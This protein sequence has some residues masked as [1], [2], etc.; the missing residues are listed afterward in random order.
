MRRWRNVGTHDPRKER[1]RRRPC[2][3]V[4]LAENWP[5]A[6]SNIPEEPTSV[7][8][9]AGEVLV[10]GSEELV[11]VGWAELSVDWVELSVG[12]AELSVLVEVSG[13][14]ELVV[15]EG[16]VSVEF[17]RDVELVKVVQ[18]YV[19]VRFRLDKSVPFMLAI[20]P[21]KSL[22]ETRHVVVVFE[23]DEGSVRLELSAPG[24]PVEFEINA[25]H[26]G[27]GVGM[28]LEGGCHD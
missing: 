14:K 1:F 5:V 19:D 22:G 8:E 23:I 10:G 12:W 24:T 28:S 20:R 7:G 21:G 11:A 15:S 2:G 9:E 18:L 6:G 3:S 27:G 16:G 4:V 17:D 25:R 26:A 13:G